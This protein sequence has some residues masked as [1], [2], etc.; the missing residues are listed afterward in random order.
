MTYRPLPPNLTIGKS[1]IE[2][3]G[4]FATKNIPKNTRLGETHYEFWNGVIIRTPLGGFINHSETPNCMK[5]SSHGDDN[6]A[7]VYY[8][9]SNRDIKKGEEITLKYTMYHL[10]ITKT[11]KDG[12]TNA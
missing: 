4:L 3:L 12:S 7:V 1:K 8:L 5:M 9:I 2:G 10:P 11:T 6:A